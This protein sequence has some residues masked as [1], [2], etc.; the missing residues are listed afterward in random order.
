M[1]DNTITAKL[2]EPII[3]EQIATAKRVYSEAHDIMK[4]LHMRKDVATSTRGRPNSQM[5]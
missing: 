4:K 5:I 3:R 1:V 2:K